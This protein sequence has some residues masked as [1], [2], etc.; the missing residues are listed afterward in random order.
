MFVDLQFFEAPQ[1]APLY[2]ALP[3]LLVCHI[4]I[5]EISRCIPGKSCKKHKVN[6]YQ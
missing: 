4:A 6:P 5:N 3:G 2:L 1:T